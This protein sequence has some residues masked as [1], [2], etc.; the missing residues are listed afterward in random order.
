[1]AVAAADRSDWLLAVVALVGLVL[2]CGL[3]PA[4]STGAVVGR[5]L[6]AWRRDSAGACCC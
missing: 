2:L 3:L 1:V 5:E 4:S 6:Y